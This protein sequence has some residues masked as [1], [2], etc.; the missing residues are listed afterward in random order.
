MSTIGPDCL[1][2]A[3]DLARTFE[4]GRDG[5]ETDEQNL[6][7]A[8]VYATLALAEATLLNA[9][10]N[11]SIQLSDDLWTGWVNA[12]GAFASPSPTKGK[13]S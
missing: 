8:Q 11:A 5:M 10:R 2:A 6:A 3:L 4:H 9:R 12:I 7:L 1:R 13:I